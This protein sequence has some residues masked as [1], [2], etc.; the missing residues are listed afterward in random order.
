MA[1]K[2][3]TLLL[4]YEPETACLQRPE[5]L[6]AALNGVLGDHLEGSGN[7]L[8]ISMQFRRDG[9]PFRVTRREL[10]A[11]FRRRAGICWCRSTACA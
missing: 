4:V 6:V 11:R 5:A 9:V 1:D 7:P 2:N 3:P 10:H 8:A